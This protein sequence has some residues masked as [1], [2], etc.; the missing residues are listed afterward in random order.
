MFIFPPHRGAIIPN[1]SP[2]LPCM[3]S[4]DSTPTI[5]PVRRT[6]RA[7]KLFYFNGK[8]LLTLSTIFLPNL[9]TV[10]IRLF[11][12]SNVELKGAAIDSNEIPICTP[13]AGEK[14]ALK[15]PR[16]LRT[17]SGRWY[18]LSFRTAL[19]VGV[20]RHQLETTAFDGERYRR[21]FSIA[22]EGAAREKKPSTNK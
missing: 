18:M 20:T 19:H 15:M 9:G 6:H 21:N 3:V 5:P 16:E 4:I 11:V 10:D 2:E 7:P 12:Y 8:K 13:T 22:V 17:G 14:V 1:V